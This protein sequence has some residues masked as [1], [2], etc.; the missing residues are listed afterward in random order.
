M[1][2]DSEGKKTLDRFNHTHQ[3]RNLDGSCGL[4]LAGQCYKAG[5]EECDFDCPHSHGEFYAGSNEWHKKHNAG[6]PV[7]GCEC[8]K[9]REEMIKQWKARA[10]KAEAERD[11][12]QVIVDRYEEWKMQKC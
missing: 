8:A 9:C 12:L 7:D 11:R 2:G 10:E 6:L 4:D 3:G 1:V 5:S